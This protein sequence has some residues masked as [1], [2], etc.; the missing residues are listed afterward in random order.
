MQTY[1]AQL[2]NNF[3]GLFFFDNTAIHQA[4]LRMM[5]QYIRKSHWLLPFRNRLKISNY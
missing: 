2:A 4:Q 3:E 1:L 5:L